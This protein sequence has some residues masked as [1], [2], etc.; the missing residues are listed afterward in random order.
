LGAGV[1]A[2][3]AAFRGAA[4]ER[5]F[6]VA[7]ANL[8][9]DPAVRL[10]G[11]GFSGVDVRLSFE[12][13]VRTLPID[14]VFFDNAGDGA[15]ALANVDAAI[16]DKVDLVIEYNGDASVSVEIARRLKAAG[17]PVLAINVPIPGA[18]LYGADNLAAGRIAGT[19][20]GQYAKENWPDETVVA[21][22]VGDLDE[23]G[24]AADR[25]RGIADGLARERADVP[26]T[27]LDSGGNPLRIE[28]LLNKFLIAESKSKVLIGALDDASALAA[29][30]AIELRRRLGDCVI[31][32]QGVD[33]T[34][35]GG[36]NDHKELDPSNRGSIV[37][38]SVA[39]YM[40]R[41]GYDVLPLAL[42]MLHGEAVPPRT[43][44]EHTLITAKTIF[45]KYPPYDMN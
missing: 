25:A 45:V 21:A 36:A 10:E 39:Y 43:T 3:V 31:V 17:I 7:F 19:A 16:A 28:G 32:S 20:L 26:V 42:K 27:R 30:T 33:R 24:P 23:A 15:K 4:Q 34:I 29:R 14:I 2:A 6:R 44:T 9:E 41:Y 11:L 12:M 1:L 8:T 5:R 37:L 40:D 18:P 38:G 22:I 35:H 13:A